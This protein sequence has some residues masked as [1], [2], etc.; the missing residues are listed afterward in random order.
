MVHSVLRRSKSDNQAN[1]PTIICALW[2]LVALFDEARADEDEQSSLQ[3]LSLALSL[4]HEHAQSKDQRL[5]I[6]VSNV[7]G[8]LGAAISPQDGEALRC[9]G[10][11]LENYQNRA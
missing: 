1:V 9:L 5:C 4:L 8:A 11:A 2:Q 7:A 6:V 3:L 10:V